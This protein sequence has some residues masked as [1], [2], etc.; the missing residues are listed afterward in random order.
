MSAA[1]IVMHPTVTLARVD[2]K[3]VRVPLRLFTGRAFRPIPSHPRAHTSTL[4]CCILSGRPEARDC[5]KTL[6]LASALA[7]FLKARHAS[8]RNAERKTPARR[9]AG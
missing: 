4:L 3:R 5:A 1:C 8:S 7:A 2:L 6:A 9:V